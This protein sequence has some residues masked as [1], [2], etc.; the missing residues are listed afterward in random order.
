MYVKAKHRSMAN[1]CYFYSGECSR[2]ILE[3]GDWGHHKSRYLHVTVSAVLPQVHY[4][5]NCCWAME[6]QPTKETGGRSN[7]QPELSHH[8][9]QG[10]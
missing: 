3:E 2:T 8:R 9:E 1:K 7:E 6:L 5:T 4:C 10:D